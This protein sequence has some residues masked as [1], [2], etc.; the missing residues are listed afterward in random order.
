MFRRLKMVGAA[1]VFLGVA[2]RGVSRAADP[3][4]GCAVRNGFHAQ[5]LTVDAAADFTYDFLLVKPTEEE[6]LALVT[7]EDVNGDGW[8]CAG[9]HDH[10]NPQFGARRLIV[11]DNNNKAKL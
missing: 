9:V 3:V 11:A 1:V 2:A 5:L 7:A 8:V 10:V 4:A 6:W